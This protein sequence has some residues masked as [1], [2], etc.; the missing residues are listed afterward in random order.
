MATVFIVPQDFH[1]SVPGQF[2]FSIYVLIKEAAVAFYDR[3][4]MFD[5]RLR[6]YSASLLNTGLYL[7]NLRQSNRKVDS[8]A[9]LLL[10]WYFFLL[11]MQVLFFLSRKRYRLQFNN[12]FIYYINSYLWIFKAIYRAS[13]M[14]RPFSNF[15]FKNW[16]LANPQN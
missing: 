3:R 4:F 5:T 10:K 6:S 7:Y 11:E 14:L 2:D 13:Q 12:R 16:V 15:K 9:N 8:L 1:K